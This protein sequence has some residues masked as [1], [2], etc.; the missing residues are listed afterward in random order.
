MSYCEASH[1]CQVIFTPIPK[2]LAGLQNSE[3]TFDNEWTWMNQKTLSE[4]VVYPE[5]AILITQNDDEPW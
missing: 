3:K 2:T 4:N 5:M 1:I